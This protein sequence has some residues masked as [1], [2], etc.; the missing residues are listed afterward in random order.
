MMFTSKKDVLT[1]QEHNFE[2]SISNEYIVNIESNRIPKSRLG[3]PLIKSMTKFMA[4]ED[5]S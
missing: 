4:N 2:S 1:W 5:I 3:A